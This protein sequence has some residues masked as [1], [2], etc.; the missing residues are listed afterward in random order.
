M[1]FRIR[2]CIFVNLIIVGFLCFFFWYKNIQV[3]HN[4]IPIS[5]FLH[6][7]LQSSRRQKYYDSNFSVNQCVDVEPRLRSKYAI[8]IQLTGDGGVYFQSALK[9]AVRL[10]W[11]LKR[12]VREETGLGFRSCTGAVLASAQCF[13]ACRTAFLLLLLSA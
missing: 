8:F 11:Y 3:T 7:Q 2:S 6:L 10:N 4:V 12:E 13:Q 1:A 9:V 5:Y